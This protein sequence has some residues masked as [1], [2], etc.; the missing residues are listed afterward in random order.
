[1][2]LPWAPKKLVKKTV[3]GKIYAQLGEI[4]KVWKNII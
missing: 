4:L 2:I 3:L 1:M